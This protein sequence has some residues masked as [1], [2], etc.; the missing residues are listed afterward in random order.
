MAS[1]A[2]SGTTF[3]SFYNLTGGIPGNIVQQAQSCAQCG[4]GGSSGSS[5]RSAVSSLSG[6]GPAMIPSGSARTW[7]YPFVDS[8]MDPDIRATNGP[9]DTVWPVESNG[10]G[11]WTAANLAN[12]Y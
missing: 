8:G 7:A 9:G 1:V 12:F 6:A 2:V 11:G 3:P 10:S 5:V 4:H